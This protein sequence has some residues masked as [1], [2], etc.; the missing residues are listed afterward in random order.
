MESA[1]ELLASVATCCTGQPLPLFLVDNHLPYPAAILQVFGVVQHGRR[2]HGH[3]R[4]KHPRLKP[5]PGLLAGVVCKIRD[6]T[7]NLLRVRTRLL[8]G[9][10]KDLRRRI[11]K[12]HIGQDINTAHIERLNGTIRGQ[13]ARL[14]R[15]TRNTSRRRRP[16]QWALWLWRD[17]Y[18]WVRPHGL[19]VRNVSVPLEVDRYTR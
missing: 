8:F 12:L 17:L 5:P 13:I 10:L 16:L 18:N 2:Q 11:R 19:V 15:R 9:T 3:G 14:G 4:F 6:A 1:A 7:G